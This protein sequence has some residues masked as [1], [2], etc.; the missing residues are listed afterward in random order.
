MYI[1]SQRS[2]FFFSLLQ[3]GF[4]FL[5]LVSPE[6]DAVLSSDDRCLKQQLDQAATHANCVPTI[7]GF[8]AREEK[9]KGLGKRDTG[10]GEKNENE[11]IRE[12]IIWLLNF[13]L[14]GSMFC[15]L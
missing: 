14:V 13:C 7:H 3:R 11:I 6:F 12:S 2:F 8:G 5:D 15:E 4:A 9:K 1:A 10:E